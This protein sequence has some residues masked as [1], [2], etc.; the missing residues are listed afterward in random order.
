[1]LFSLQLGGLVMFST[2][3]KRIA[4]GVSFV[5]CAL[6]VSATTNDAA[7][8]KWKGDNQGF[9]CDDWY[10][11][12]GRNGG[13]YHR[14]EDGINY[15]YGGMGVGSGYGVAQSNYIY[16][17]Y[18]GDNIHRYDAPKYYQQPAVGSCNPVTGRYLT[19]KGYWKFCR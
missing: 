11:C 7:A 9:H 13:V 6:T 4:V 5:V 12:E 1:M 17:Y 19:A 2:L 16:N 18:F 15:Y 10:H 8:K 14:S 3:L